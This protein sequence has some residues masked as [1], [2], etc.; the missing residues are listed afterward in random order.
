MSK[1]LSEKCLKA[2]ITNPSFSVLLNRNTNIVQEKIMDK[3]YIGPSEKD[4]HGEVYG[5]QKQVNFN[6][7]NYFIK[8]GMSVDA[9]KRVR[10]DWKGIP[11]FTMYTPYRKFTE[12]LTHLL[13]DY[14]R[15]E[16]LMSDNT[17]QI[18]WFYIRNFEE[19]VHIVNMVAH[20]SKKYALKNKNNLQELNN[21]D[22]TNITKYH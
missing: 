1:I 20:I 5:Y 11:I 19:P 10:K 21:I 12:R 3:L 8:I 18:E 13:L 15:Y 2:I 17:K 14:C 9:Q 16:I 6:T 22:Y 4:G 7:N